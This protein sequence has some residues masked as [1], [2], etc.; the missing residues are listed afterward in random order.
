MVAAVEALARPGVDVIVVTR[1]GGSREDLW[2]FNDERLAR[3]IA[4]SPVPVVSAV[5]H[6]IDVTVADL[7]ADARAATPTHAAQLVAPVRDDLLAGLA[8]LRGR[9]HRAID[10]R[11]STRRRR[12]LRALLAEL[13]DPTHLLSAQ[14]HRLEDLLRRAEAGAL[15]AAEARAGAAGAAAGPAGPRPSRGPGCGRCGRGSRRRARRLEGW[16]AATF[17]RESLRLAAARGPA[18]AG[19]RGPAAP[20]RLR[21]GARTTAGW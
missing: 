10:R 11:P 16:Q 9:L 3:A 20:A 1:G 2:A 18:R 12:D 19:Q 5:G 13:G 8:G 15:R 7:V 14:R 17:R 21:A 4:A 6:E